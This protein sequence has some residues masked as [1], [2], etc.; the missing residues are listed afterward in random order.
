MQR[1]KR[2]VEADL[3]CRTIVK[4]KALAM[5]MCDGPTLVFPRFNVTIKDN[6]TQD[7]QTYG[8]TDVRVHTLGSY[9]GFAKCSRR[10]TW[11]SSGKSQSCAM[12][13][14]ADLQSKSTG[15]PCSVLDLRLPLTMGL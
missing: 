15:T 6:Y 7:T 12:A 2:I 9:T 5:A 3:Q 10:A 4:E 11:A 1:H 14:A 8:G 13:V